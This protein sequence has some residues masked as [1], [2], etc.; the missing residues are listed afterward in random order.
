MR[1]LYL[2]CISGIAGDMTL[3]ALVDL[4][5]DPTYIESHLRKLPI[6]DFTMAFIP[7]NRK[8]ITA[9]WLDLK[10]AEHAHSHNHEHDHGHSHTHSHS[11][12]H[13]HGH[14]HTHS[15]SHDHDHDHA[16][17]HGHA[18]A[19]SHDHGHHHDHEHRKAT[20]IMAMIRSSSMPERVKARSI[21]IFEVIAAAEGKIHGMDPAE[22]HFHEVGAM[23]SILDIIGV[24]LA[25][26]SLDIGEIIVSPVPVGHG[27]IRIAHGVYPIPAPATAEILTGVPLSAFTAQGE[28]TTPTGAGIAKALAASFGSTPGGVIERIGY[29]AGTKDFDHPNV[30]RAVLYRESQSASDE[31]IAV[32]ETQVDDMTGERLGYTMDRLFAA[33]AL[34]V[35][36]TPVFM[37]K[38]RP[39]VLLTV[40]CQPKDKVRC[41]DILLRETSTFGVRSYS[42]DRRILSRSWIDVNTRYGNVRVKQAFEGEK[43]VKSAPE[44]EDAAEAARQF[45]VAL[46]EV[47]QEV[48]RLLSSD[49]TRQ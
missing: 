8:G 39:G 33:G 44:Y 17:S 25:L 14:S 48:Y 32:L 38:N 42:A 49:R 43:L 30:I 20:D 3:S 47:Y 41:E 19:H 31:T 36:Y 12:D 2:D 15:H 13:D 7:V 28:L 9:K 45:G 11:H 4:G 27:R 1:T 24:C 21:A 46:E 26:E 18:H 37:K 10:F 22:V 29:G 16:P 23:D 35:Y 6:D 5:A 34:D 40:L